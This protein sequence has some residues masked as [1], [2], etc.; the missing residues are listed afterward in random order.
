MSELTTQ[1]ITT[2]ARIA[3]AAG[4]S[5]ADWT[6]DD[7]VQDFV[8]EHDGPDSDID[9]WRAAFDAGEVE[10][11]AAQGWVS[12]W[13][14]APADYDCFGTTTAELCGDWQGKPLRR[15]LCHPH[16][17]DYQE[18]RNGS[19]MHPTWSEDPRI[20]EREAAE[21]RERWRAEDA[22]RAAKRAVGLAWLAAATEVEI[23][24]AKD[25]DEVE[26]RGLTYEDI[27]DDCERR[28]ADRADRARDAEWERCRASFQDGAILVDDGTPGQR[29]VYGWI[30]GQ[31]TRVYYEVRVTG[32][33]RKVADEAMVEGV[34]HDRA[35]S[36]ALVADEI[37]NGRLRIVSPNDV[38][39]EPVV[40]RIGHECY[41]E[42][43]RV[44]AA[45]RVVWVGRTHG[46]ELLVLDSAGKLARAK[47]VVAAATAA[48]YA[49]GHAE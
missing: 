14:T 17:V 9:A 40:R 2:L 31:P 19:G 39:P 30:P 24:D 10:Y 43:R 15:I 45:G 47:A 36:L 32:D 3:G 7:V 21:R 1:D 44:E 23:E 37:A 13:T 33:W 34:G 49:D 5:W 12:R 38:P 46:Y 48:F 25:L 41:R 20:E 22:A 28:A 26:S 27:R 11:R 8:C 18:G 6:C 16:H 29:G 35:G 4:R 42:I